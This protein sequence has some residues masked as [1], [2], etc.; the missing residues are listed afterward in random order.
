MIVI[1]LEVGPLAANAY[2]LREDD[3][4][5]GAV[6]DPGDEGDRIVER[7]RTEGLEPRLIINTH[8]HMDH[9]AANG[10]LKDAFPE[11]ELCI[12]AGDAERLADPVGNLSAMFGRSDAG[13]APD[14]LL[15]DGEG[16]GFGSVALTVLATPG[17]TPGGI[18][19]LARDESPPQLFCGDLVFRLGVGR[20]DLPGGSWHDLDAAIRGK[21]FC[22]PDDTV[23]WPGHGPP[24]TV[25]QERQDNPFVG[26]AGP[27]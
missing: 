6:I 17:H 26:S 9:I 23:I 24:T 8:A 16:V 2:L 11:A 18:C 7:C 5:G 3:G 14:R 20:T 21:V 19:L 1:P 27:L 25:A 13:P 12:G 4:P 10:D 15:E 22:L